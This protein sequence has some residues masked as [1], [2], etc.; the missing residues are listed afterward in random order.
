MWPG[1]LQT[2]NQTDIVCSF[3]PFV[4]FY[5]CHLQSGD[6]GL[7]W[8]K[9]L[10]LYHPPQPDR[11]PQKETH[12]SLQTASHISEAHT[13]SHSR[14]S[15]QKHN[16]PF[17]FL[18]GGMAGAAGWA[19]DCLG[20]REAW[21]HRT[22]TLPQISTQTRDWHHKGKSLKFVSVLLGGG[23]G[24]RWWWWGGDKQKKHFSFLGFRALTCWDF[25]CS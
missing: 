19:L 15:K 6:K 1:I 9:S 21:A 23:G 7:E 11:V 20:G 12:A 2:E 18:G 14:L 5:F 13:A 4:S 3:C 16:T 24:E 17:V 22:L 25:K 8:T 10:Q